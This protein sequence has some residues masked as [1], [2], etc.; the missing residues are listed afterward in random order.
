[1]GRKYKGLCGFSTVRER[2]E[3]TWTSPFWGGEGQVVGTE[4]VGAGDADRDG[5]G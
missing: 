2:V 5:T 1:M 3:M 4:D